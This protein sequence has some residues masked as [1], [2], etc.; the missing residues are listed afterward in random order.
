MI[1]ET[2]G[3]RLQGA[4]KPLIP[5]VG[6][7][8]PS[9]TVPIVRLLGRTCYQLPAN[10]FSALSRITRRIDSSSSSLMHVT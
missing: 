9:F 3:S 4:V 2:L 8:Q 5:S 10:A 6:Q 7:S 1:G